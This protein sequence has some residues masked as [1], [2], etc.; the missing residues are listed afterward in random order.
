MSKQRIRYA[1]VLK[2][3]FSGFLAAREA[4]IKAGRTSNELIAMFELRVSFINGCSY[5]INMHSE[6][7]L[8]LNVADRKVREIAAWQCS[9]LFD[10]KQ[11]VA[12]AWADNLTNITQTHV[13]DEEFD[14]I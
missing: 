2:E 13:S 11:R 3:S 8:H 12:F 10:V 7:L 6:E 1:S 5:C 4:V 9:H 14:N